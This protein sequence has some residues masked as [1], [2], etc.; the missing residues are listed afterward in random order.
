[1]SHSRPSTQDAQVNDTNN[2]IDLTVHVDT[3][4]ALL[5]DFMIYD[6]SSHILHFIHL[7]MNCGNTRKNLLCDGVD[8]PSS[9]L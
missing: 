4:T 6:P 9:G 2:K 5:L 1:M 7:H 8:P 3:V